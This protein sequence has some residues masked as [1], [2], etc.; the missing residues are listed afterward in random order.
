VYVGGV[1]VGL[2]G[3]GAGVYVG[4]VG[5]GGVGVGVYVGGVGLGLGVYVGGVGLCSLGGFS[6]LG[7]CSLGGLC[8]FGGFSGLGPLVGGFSGFGVGVAGVGVGVYPYPASAWIST[9]RLTATRASSRAALPLPPI[10]LSLSHTLSNCKLFWLA[11]AGQWR[12]GGLRRDAHPATAYIHGGRGGVGASDA[13][14]ALVTPFDG[15][16]EERERALRRERGIQ[17]SH[18]GAAREAS[19]MVTRFACIGV[20]RHR[21]LVQH[22]PV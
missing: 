3:V 6:G 11:L 20:H 7:P 16:E 5:L 10:I 21:S 12:S 14:W 9:A 17:A 13:L 8:S 22:G 19:P 18:V 15:E 2:W 1:G 4:G